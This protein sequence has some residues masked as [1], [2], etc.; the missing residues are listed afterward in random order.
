MPMLSQ[1]FGQDPRDATALTRVTCRAP[2]S[3]RQ[4]HWLCSKSPQARTRSAAPPPSGCNTEQ[5]VSSK[6]TSG[7]APAEGSTPVC[8]R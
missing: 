2:S 6:R 4:E 3:S 1:A 8:S 5:A 7:A